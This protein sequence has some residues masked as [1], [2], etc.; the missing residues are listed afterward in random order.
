MGGRNDLHDG[1]FLGD[2]MEFND[3]KNSI[4]A[5]GEL[6]CPPLDGVKDANLNRVYY[7]AIFPNMLLSLHPEYVM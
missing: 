2:Y 3:D 4:T 5:S 6:C 1:P 7:Y